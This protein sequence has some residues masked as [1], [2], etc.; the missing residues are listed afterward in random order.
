MFEGWIQQIKS[1]GFD[2]NKK[3][4]N[5]KKRIVSNL[6]EKVSNMKKQLIYSKK[7]MGDKDVRLMK[8]KATIQQ[9]KDIAEVRYVMI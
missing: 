4:L 2:Q 3:E 7:G 8:L 5:N 6:E 9:E 1:E